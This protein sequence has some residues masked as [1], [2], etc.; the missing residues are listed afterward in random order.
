MTHA[1]EIA[2]Q[3]LGLGLALG[4]AVLV[5]RST[6]ARGILPPGF[7]RSP[8]RRGAAFVAVAAFLW[9]GIFATVGLLGQHV[10][11]DVAHLREP[12]LF[13]LHALMLLTLAIWFLLGFAGRGAAPLARVA[14]PEPPLEAPPAPLPEASAAPEA[15]ATIAEPA[16]SLR[17][18]QSVS[19]WRRF[20]QQFGLVAPSVPRELAL[21][22][23]LG[24]VAWA[25]VIALLLVIVLIL[26]AAGF[27]GVLPKRPPAVVPWIAALPFG[28]RVAVALSAGFFEELFF[29]GFLQP[30]IGILLSTA[31]FT[32]AHLSYGQPFLLIGVCALSLAYGFLVRWRQSIWVTVAAHSFFDGIQLLV[33]VPAVMRY[34]EGAAG[35]AKGAGTLSLSLLSM[36]AGG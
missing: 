1:G 17:P 32:L 26:L 10:E 4:A 19:L 11:I 18:L 29:R 6:E 21:G 7:A 8:W 22:L 25:A 36:W 2:L 35:A 27:E 24:I 13:L 28:L 31:L 15:L 20:C 5:D 34:L 12:R 30:R 16:P 33:I 3:A 23:G 9:I 14:A